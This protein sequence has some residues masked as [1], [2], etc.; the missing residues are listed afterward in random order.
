MKYSAHG[1]RYPQEGVSDRPTCDEN[2]GVTDIGRTQIRPAGLEEA[3]RQ[4][5]LGTNGGGRDKRSMHPV[6]GWN[7]YLVGRRA[8]RK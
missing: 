7:L 1:E 4:R 5:C 6:E 2:I 3:S 8:E